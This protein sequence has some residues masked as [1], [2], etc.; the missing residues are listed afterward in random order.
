M[1]R[2]PGGYGA[3]IVRTFLDAARDNPLLA[4]RAGYGF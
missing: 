1:K 4:V 3:R 2:R